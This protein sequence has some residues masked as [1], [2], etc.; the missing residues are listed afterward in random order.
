MVVILGINTFRSGSS[1]A[2]L[3]DGVPVATMAV[4]RLNRVTCCRH[5]LG[6]AIRRCL[7]LGGVSFK[8]NDSVAIG[9]DSAANRARKMEFMLRNRSKLRKLLKITAARGAMD[10]L[11]SS[12]AAECEADSELLRFEVVS[13]EHT[14]WIRIGLE[15]SFAT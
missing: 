10:D 3:V 6:L 15:F 13:V 9:R 11:R 14:F 7:G 1:A 12:I 4:E 8:D 5:L 2:P